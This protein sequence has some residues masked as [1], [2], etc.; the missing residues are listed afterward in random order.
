MATI[1]TSYWHQ[2]AY[3]INNNNIIINDNHNINNIN[4][5]KINDINN[6]E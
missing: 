2:Y 5:K 4:N 6:D 3:N 1:I